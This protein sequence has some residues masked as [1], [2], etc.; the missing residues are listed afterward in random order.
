[1]NQPGDAPAHDAA[2]LD[3]LDLTKGAQWVELERGVG[4]LREIRD[5]PWT[6][7]GARD[8]GVRHVPF[9]KYPPLV[10]RVTELLYEI[11]AITPAYQ[12]MDHEPPRPGDDG[13]IGAADAV[14]L[15]TAVVRGERFGDGC[16]AK[17]LE[18]GSFA[19]AVQA[20][21]TW[22]RSTSHRKDHTVVSTPNKRPA[23]G[24]LIGSAIGDAMGQ[25]T[26]FLA[27]ER[28]EAEYGPWRQ[29]RF[30][31]RHDGVA[32]VTDDTEMTLAVARALRDAQGAPGSPGPS[33]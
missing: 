30:P 14:R 27:V 6:S 25:P 11:G 26:E 16:I 4:P 5:V 19:G 15:L 18:N 2:L 8:E 31:V 29:M 7:P 1:M 17:A 24:A 12:W 32:L 33:G 20:L 9:P 22:R 3:Q 23:T 13:A 21:I 10:Q 28:I